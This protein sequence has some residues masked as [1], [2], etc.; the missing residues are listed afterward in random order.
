MTAALFEA[1]P[2]R[3]LFSADRILAACREDINLE[4]SGWE[5]RETELETKWRFSALLSL[6][7]RPRLAASGGTTHVFDKVRPA[8]RPVMMQLCSPVS[9]DCLKA[10]KVRSQQLPCVHGRPGAAV[11]KGCSGPT[12]AGDWPGGE[13]Y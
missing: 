1:M 12:P 4:V 11:R 13:A 5:E 3:L 8:S 2:T 10:G 9:L 6:P 7:W